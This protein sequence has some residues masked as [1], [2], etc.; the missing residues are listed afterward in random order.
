MEQQKP[1]K[2][3]VN[4]RY[5]SEVCDTRVSD[6]HSTYKQCSM[7][8]QSYYL[9][10]TIQ[11]ELKCATIGFMFISTRQNTLSVGTKTPTKSVADLG[12]GGWGGMHPPPPA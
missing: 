1:T 5:I 4:F 11:H 8:K 6:F 7:P 10:E 3:A 9:G 2:Y 12:G